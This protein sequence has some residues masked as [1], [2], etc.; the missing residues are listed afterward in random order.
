VTVNCNH[1]D[2]NGEPLNMGR[3]V[4]RAS[5]HA[6]PS[7]QDEKASLRGK[8]GSKSMNCGLN[9]GVNFK[10]NFDVKSMP[11]ALSKRKMVI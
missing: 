10:R 5:S 3:G 4:I 11:T 8:I 9:V 7:V 1:D 2:V 6:D